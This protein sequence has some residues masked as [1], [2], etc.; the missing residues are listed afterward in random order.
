M[1]NNG[2]DCHGMQMVKMALRFAG[3]FFVNQIDMAS[4]VAS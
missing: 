3:P 1:I 2:N 4:L